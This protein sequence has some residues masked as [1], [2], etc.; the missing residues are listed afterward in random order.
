MTQADLDDIHAYMRELLT[1]KEADVDAIYSCTHGFDDNCECRKPKVGMLLAAA[2]DFDIDL[3]ESI[4]VG[5]KE[6]D[7]VAGRAAGCKVNIVWK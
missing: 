6:S 7:M 2:H 5:D 3:S 4:M 1:A